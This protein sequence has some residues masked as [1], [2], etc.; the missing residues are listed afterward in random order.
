MDNL[1]QYSIIL[2]QKSYNRI[3]KYTI[4]GERHSGTNWLEK[5]I[6]SKF[7]LE[8][9]WEF[10]SK[11]FIDTLDIN[12]M[13]IAKS[14]VFICIS[15]NIYDWI[16]GFYKSPHH[17]NPEIIGS[18]DKFL[19]SEWDC[20][21]LDFNFFTKLKYKNIFELRTL[22]LL[23]YYLFL[24]N[25]VDNMI[26]IRY[27]DLINNVKQ[28]MSEISSII[29]IQIK[30]ETYS[31]IL[32]PKSKVPYVLPKNILQIININTDWSVEKLYKYRS[33]II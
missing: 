21:N 6:S 22:K 5:L 16:G 2:S 4:L 7:E 8:L 9:T 23:Y 13:S 18:L 24:P 32:R 11:H 33:K 29:D 17:V 3:L 28:V 1:D 19:L 20:R 14:T 15:R 10:G 30:D 25:I 26:I 31:K 12:K 27:E